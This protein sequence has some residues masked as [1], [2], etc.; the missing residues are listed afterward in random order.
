MA[1]K[2]T[3]KEVAEKKEDKKSDARILGLR[4]TEKSAKGSELG[5]YTFNIPTTV[6]KIEVAK[7]I[8]KLY[9]VTPIKVAITKRMKKVKMIRGKMGTKSGG[10]KAVVYLK[11]GDKIDFAK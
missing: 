9:G 7:A 5:A 2:K 3:T 11:K 6:N 8:K 1:T 10:K 4:V